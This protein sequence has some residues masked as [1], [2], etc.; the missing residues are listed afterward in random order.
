VQVGLGELDYTRLINQLK[1]QGYTRAL[2]VDILPFPEN[3][4]ERPLELRKLRMLLDTL[5]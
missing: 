2:S 1:R 3:A 5:L 4:N